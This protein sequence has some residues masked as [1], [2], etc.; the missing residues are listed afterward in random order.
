MNTESEPEPAEES[1][2]EVVDPPAEST[3]PRCDRT[4]P[5]DSPSQLCPY[6]LL[7]AD[8]C[9]PTADWSGRLSQQFQPPTTEELQPF[10]EMLE[11]G[12]LL[13]HGGMGA[14][15]RAHQHSLGRDVALK[16]LLPEVAAADGF[17]ERFLREARALARLGHP[18]VVAVFDH[19][20]AGPYAYLVMELVEGINLR[21]LMAGEKLPVEDALRIVPQLCDALQFAHA[22]GVVHRDIKPENILIEDSGHVK[23]TDF[24]LAKLGES[25]DQYGRTATRQVMGTVHYMAPEQIE[26]PREVDHRADLYSLGVVF[27]ELLTGELPLGRF[28][29]PSEKAGS[30][31]QV[32]R[33]VLK[34]LEKE[35]NRRYASADE[36]RS[37]L[38]RNTHSP[39]GHARAAADAVDQRFRQAGR[40]MRSAATGLPASW[41]TV[42][43]TVATVSFYMFSLFGLMIASNSRDPIGPFLSVVGAI[44]LCAFFLAR[45]YESVPL[46]R[47][48]E[49]AGKP[50][51]LIGQF[52]SW[53]YGRL[54][55]GAKSIDGLRMP[56]MIGGQVAFVV[57]LGF[58]FCVFSN[59]EEMIV[60][61]LIAAPIAWALTRLALPSDESPQ[62][63]S[64]K[65]LTYPPILLTLVPV[66]VVVLAWPAFAWLALIIRNPPEWFALTTGIDKGIDEA[67]LAGSFRM[68]KAQLFG[69]IAIESGWLSFWTF[70][71]AFFPEAARSVMRPILDQWS[72]K[73]RW[74]FFALCLLVFAISSLV[75]SL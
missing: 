25:D 69:A 27:Y 23:I 40:A 7:S 47:F 6:C 31:R 58:L 34:S 71:I 68:V 11:V 4:L 33:V 5:P 1:D 53:A 62:T 70:C 21:E 51:A 17:T 3:C 12:P 65:F 38:D 67:R 22:R 43:V 28:C 29:P 74:F 32:D 44:W 13:G 75:W 56:W 16:I 14:V 35:P 26:R 42:A 46:P 57:A 30:S 2:L 54:V 39:A 20:T 49:P 61:A 10:F 48:F 8:T 9:E 36:V 60:G 18:N 24:G 41:V 45:S 15:Y 37:D 50:I 52:P 73:G 59:E 19:G 64:A 72:G 66:L 63:P 55:E